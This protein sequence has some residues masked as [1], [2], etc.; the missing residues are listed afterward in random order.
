MKKNK[1]IIES[2]KQ[3]IGITGVHGHIGSHF[4]QKCISLGYNVVKLRRDGKVPSKV[5][6]VFD[7][8]SYGNKYDQTDKKKIYEANYDRVV[9][10]INNC[11]GKY[12]FL[13]STSSVLLPIQTDYSES[14]A[15]MEEFV[16]KWVKETG[17]NIIVV[18]P[19]T[20]IGVGENPDHLIPRLIRSCLYGEP[21]DFVSKPTHDFIDVEDF[22][23][24][25]LFLS[26]FIEKYKGHIFNLSFALSLT[27]EFI[28][29]VVEDVTGKKAVIKKVKSLRKYDTT[30]WIVN[31]D[32]LK[33]LGWFPRKTL[34][35]SIREMVE[36][37]KT[38]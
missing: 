4:H 34:F 11:K 29:A 18:R 16:K 14:K 8:A 3:V 37:Y 27:N 17:E 22:V 5:T 25:L 38:K 33:A 7:F 23:N 10:L 12:L 36:E 31:N 6:H 20:V 35:D 1:E 15:K 26:K 28:K 24:A 19:S 30:K 32:K 21:M 9:K 2:Q 13:V